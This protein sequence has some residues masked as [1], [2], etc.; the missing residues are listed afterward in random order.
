MRSATSG[1]G[2]PVAD[3][4]LIVTGASRGIGA[5]TARL[6]GAR[7]YPVCVNHRDSEPEA[8]KLA[9]EIQAAGGRAIAVGADVGRP[10]AVARLFDVTERSLGRV[11]ML[12]N[13]AGITGGLSLLRDLTPEALEHVMRTNVMGTFHCCR[14]AVQRMTTTGGGKGGAI[15][16]VTSQAARFGGQ[17]LLHYAAS[18]AALET[19]TVGLAREVAGEGIRVN[20]VSPGLI[21]TDPRDG[22]R[23]AGPDDRVGTIPL[24]RFGRPEEVAEAILWLLSDA[25]SYVT[26]TVLP[27]AGGR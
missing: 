24:G 7:G 2:V 26:G 8:R 1:S 11:G 17:R 15:V 19:L 22:T 16:N 9:D 20:A 14:E 18:K 10:D 13:N 27:V 4:A 6:A 23:P 25:S 5:A 21:D 12:V 3:R